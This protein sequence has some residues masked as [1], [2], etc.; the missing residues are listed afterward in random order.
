MQATSDD[1]YLWAL[2]KG[3]NIALLEEAALQ[4]PIWTVHKMIV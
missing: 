2:L 4:E 1:S 3:G